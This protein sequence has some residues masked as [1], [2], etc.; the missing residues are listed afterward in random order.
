MFR[1]PL[2]SMSQG[3]SL[4]HGM[5]AVQIVQTWVQNSIT[6]IRGWKWWCAPKIWGLGKQRQE[7]PWGFWL[8]NLANQWALGSVGKPFPPPSKWRLIE[9]ISDINL[10]HLLMYPHMCTCSL[11]IHTHTHTLVITPEYLSLKKL[12]RVLFGDRLLYCCSV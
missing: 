10:W 9:N 4:L 5:L 8:A 2:M 6:H 12:K 1:F 11:T 7:D 3:V